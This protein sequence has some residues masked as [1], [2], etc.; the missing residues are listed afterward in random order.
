MV[1]M[2]DMLESVGLRG[3]RVGRVSSP[4]SYTQCV[5]WDGVYFVFVTSR[6]AK[7]RPTFYEKKR[8]KQKKIL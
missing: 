2:S 4:L 7:D 5:V 3:R 1:K 6:I 8:N